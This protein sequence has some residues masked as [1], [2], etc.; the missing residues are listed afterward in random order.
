[1]KLQRQ[2]IFLALFLILFSLSGRL[3]FCR[4]WQT[5]SYT[6]L[7]GLPNANV[8]GITQDRD[9]R[10]WFATR[11]GISCYDGVSW[12]N[13]TAEEGLPAL[14]FTGIAVDRQGRI[15][16]FPDL[17]NRISAVFY[18]DAHWKPT[19]VKKIIAWKVGGIT[20]FEL[21]DRE[22]KTTVVVGTGRA[23]LFWW[24]EGSWG[25]LTTKNGLLSDCIKG[26]AVLQG[27]CYVI[28][29]K[30]LSIVKKNLT[31]DN[32]ANE[33]LDFPAAEISG[34]CVEENEIWLFGDKYVGYFNENSL[35]TVYFDTGINFEN[36]KDRVIL[37][38]DYCGG[39]YIGN[40]S[41]LFYFNYK[42][43][44]A[45]PVGT[46][47]GIIGTGVNAMF[48]DFEKNIW[49][50]GSR[51][52]TKIVSRRF[53]SFQRIDGLLED[54]VSAVLEYKPGKF[55]LGHNTG[56]TFFDGD[57]FQAVP[58]YKKVKDRP[59]P[60]RVLDIKTDSS[61][62]TWI[63]FAE[64][65]VIRI[66]KRKKIKRYGVDQDPPL[67]ASS[68][69]IDNKDTLWIGTKQGVSYITAS[70]ELRKAG[71]DFPTVAISLLYG[72]GGKLSC[73]G[74]SGSGIY[75]YENNRW[76]NYRAAGNEKA[77]EVFSI[78]QHGDRLLL[79]TGAGL[80][81][82]G[83]EAPVKFA[84][85]GFD[86]DR[87]VYFITEDH[88]KR[89]WFGT[90]DGV[91]R[92]DGSEKRKYSL[93]EGLI[94][95]ETNRAA[96][97]ADSSG[98]M[99]IGTG[100]G[101][102]VYNE[103][104]D[105]ELNRYPPKIRLLDLE[106]QDR[107]IPLDQPLRLSYKESGMFF[108]FRG[109][110]FIDED[111]LEFKYKLQG[112]DKEWSEEQPHYT[113]VVNYPALQP[114]TYRF[115]LQAK[116]S[117]GVW[118]EKITSPPIT[119]LQPY[120][121]QWWFY[122]TIL[123]MLGV[124]FYGLVRF[125]SARRR[126]AK[127]ARLIEETTDQ[128]QASEKRY[129]GLFEDSQDAVLV[130]S[131]AG[132]ILD[133]NPSGVELFGCASKEEVTA[134]DGD[135]I[136]FNPMDRTIF[137]NEIEEKGYVKDYELD[138]KRKNGEQISVLV[139][140]AYVTVEKGKPG[141]I[142]G[143]VRDITEKKK[144]RQ[145][146][147]QARKMEAIGRLAGGIAHDFNNILTVISG[148]LEL[149]LDMLPEGTEVWEYIDQVNKSAD[150]A[151][152]LVK[153][154]LTFSRQGVQE[155][156]PLNLCRVVDEA[157]KLFKVML[158]AAVEIRRDTACEY[159]LISADTMQIQQVMMNLFSNAAYAM[160]DG[161]GVL[162]VG[163]HEVYLDEESAAAY[164]DI[165]PGRYLRLTVSDTGKGI[166]PAILKRIFEP[167]FTTRKAGESTGMG[168]AVIHGIIKNHN[169]E[170]TVYSEPEHGTTFKVL[171]PLVEEAEKVP[172]FKEAER[173]P[174]G[175]NERVLF[176][177]DEPIL[178][179]MEQMF[180]KNLGYRVTIRTGSREA[181]EL[182]RAAPQ[183]FDLVITD[184]I[185]PGMSG[186]RL[187]R[188]IMEIRGDIPVILCTGFSETVTAE[189]RESLGIRDV[190][191]KPVSRNIMART[192]REALEKK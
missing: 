156:K 135:E 16:A 130:M 14:S 83:Q 72:P 11:S 5:R 15:W 54:E 147:E 154:V 108:H 63:A 23:G 160:R 38:P 74:S 80:Y 25:N 180:L 26:T 13:H 148:Y 149:A 78:K 111:S 171:L 172:G 91:V 3:S 109:V 82:L 189:Q 77:N 191:M 185:M 176:V 144:L 99:W 150:R 41:Q 21:L 157:V 136:Y 71:G 183:D 88:K 60:G 94:G 115:C 61:Q 4:K 84:E 67:Y 103:F 98:R 53:S 113:Q 101:V 192:V 131:L 121:K 153:Q 187:A 46:N 112:Y 122:L 66:D 181:L 92:W 45:Q 47:N 31:I 12:K 161:G 95:Q 186:I 143:F 125:I 124:I 62:D 35:K 97:A 39:L 34:I 166:E 138:L 69:W 75:L 142:R 43:K 28:T 64:A 68:L 36:K 188:E 134:F 27:K 56:V 10:M 140:A 73:L 133:I 30:G 117:L 55:V 158:P 7:S 116:N 44:E 1:M 76:K 8:Y 152:E 85:K 79:G 58:F 151:K 37:Q 70:G 139:T 107:R 105:S 114:G 110:S 146:L 50:A 19:K 178:V 42:T 170:I 168:L 129:R 22:G 89:L 93:A 81:V 163:L 169:G 40:S 51:G 102:S 90:D 57:K 6:G 24:Q 52:V 65:G 155:M 29:D 167:Y 128:L 18:E 127:L 49:I 165:G 96:G 59:L 87:P 162:A 182:F 48:L 106:M 174:F 119:I 17:E 123:L 126:A 120:Y 33:S 104:F 190:L 164:N 179:E 175:S 137:S 145:Q 20:S 32:E 100:S 184:L 177:D 132:K 173:I 86:I 159:G 9:G 118:S 2:K 141:L